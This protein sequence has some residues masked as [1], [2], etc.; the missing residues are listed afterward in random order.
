MDIV[1]IYTSRYYLNVIINIMQGLLLL[2]TTHVISGP[3]DWTYISNILLMFV[4][5]LGE[6]P[7]VSLFNDIT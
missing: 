4:Q 5:S 6:S 2:D 3:K 7:D 1:T